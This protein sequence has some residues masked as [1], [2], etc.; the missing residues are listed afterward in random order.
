MP[1]RKLPLI[2]PA[3]WHHRLVPTPQRS[4]DGRLEAGLTPKP[5]EPGPL[6]LA[7]ASETLPTKLSPHQ[8]TRSPSLFPPQGQVSGVRTAGP[9]EYL[10]FLHSGAQASQTPAQREG[11]RAEIVRPEGRERWW[12]QTLTPRRPLWG[13]CCTGPSE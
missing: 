4:Q 1:F 8:P 13:T 12:G 9:G 2:Y 10:C 6:L 11:L 3:P 7:P 5:E